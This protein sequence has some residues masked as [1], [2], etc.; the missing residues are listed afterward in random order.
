MATQRQDG[1]ATDCKESAEDLTGKEFYFATRDSTGKLA[2]CGNGEK[3]AG[4]ISEGRIAGKH[5]SINTGGQLKVIAGGSISVGD[6]VQSDGN[7]KA[8]TGSTN[9]F[10]Y[11]INAASAG[12]MVEIAVDRV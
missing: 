1:W 6:N 12:E 4:V 11:A 9:A 3:I 2:L 8:V 10:G 7:G 5:T